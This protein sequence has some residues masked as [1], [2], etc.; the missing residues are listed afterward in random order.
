MNVAQVWRYP[1]KSMRGEELTQAIL[2]ATGLAGDRAYAI[3]DRQTGRVASAKDPR[4][5]PDLLRFRTT[6]EGEGVCIILPDGRTVRSSETPDAALSEA[7]GR[8]VRLCALGDSEAAVFEAIWPDVEGVANR[9]AVT[10]ERLPPGSFHDVAPLHLLTT[11][12]LD[13]LAARA[14]D[15][16]FDPRRFRPN[17]L[18][19][20]EPERTGFVENDWVGRTLAV[21]DMVRLRVTQPCSR[22]VMTTLSQEDLPHDSRVLQSVARHNRACAGVYAVVLRPGVV[23]RGDPA[24]IE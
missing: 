3:V 1:V 2:T 15:S 8:L 17:L 19:A 13:T 20:T 7:L 14:P 6:M 9:G 22:C 23:R 16:R 18:L 12:T 11:A 4:R 21:G 5:W 10:L 24:R